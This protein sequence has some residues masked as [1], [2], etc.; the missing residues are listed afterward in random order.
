M[1]MATTIRPNSISKF[2]SIIG[3]TESGGKPLTLCDYTTDSDVSQAMPAGGS[4][5]RFRAAW[6]WLVPVQ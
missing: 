6:K 1:P 3:N 2:G 4:K 5:V